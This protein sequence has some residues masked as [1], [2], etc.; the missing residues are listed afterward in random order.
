MKKILLGTVLS[1]LL[2]QA[3]FSSQAL[4]NHGGGACG[5]CQA[6]QCELTEKF[7]QKAHTLWL[8]Q[9][10]FEL[11][12]EQVQAIK[13]LKIETKKQMIRDYADMEILSMDIKVG[14]WGEIGRAH[15]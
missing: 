10:E 4:A 11:T 12:K 7:I 13:T 8:N 2:L 6:K 15:V 5:Q 14:L 9:E 3:G 1:V